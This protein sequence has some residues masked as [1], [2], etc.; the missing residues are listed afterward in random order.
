[1]SPF[2]I[3]HMPDEAWIRVKEIY[4]QGMD[5]K[6]ATFEVH[7]PEWTLWNNS[8]R[9][10]CR[11]IAK[12]DDYIIGW[13]ALSNVSLRTVYSGVAEVS[14]YVDL[15]YQGKG[16]GRLLLERLIEESEINEIW[17]LQAGIFPEN[18]AS[19]KLHRNHGFRVIGVREKIGKMDG[20]WRNVMLLERRSKVVGIK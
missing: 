15:R 20:T 8:H 7:A 11:L 2:V 19:L 16:I 18:K 17:T 4:Q 9:K 13:A 14:I 6:N 3:T 10:D 12:I 5:T 1:M